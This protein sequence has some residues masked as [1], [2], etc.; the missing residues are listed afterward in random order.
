MSVQALQAFCSTTLG[1][2]AV[3][4]GMQIYQVSMYLSTALDL[5]TKFR[6]P[7]KENCASFA[8]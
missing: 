6:R 5:I 2:G 8:N 1:N 4:I 3:S 7:E